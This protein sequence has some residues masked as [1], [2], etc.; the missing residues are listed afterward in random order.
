M[1][2]LRSLLNKMNNELFSML[3][4]AITTETL[5]TIEV[6][7]NTKKGIIGKI[8]TK[9]KGVE[10]GA[11]AD[12]LNRIVSLYPNATSRE[13]F[14]ELVHFLHWDLQDASGI[15]KPKSQTMTLVQQAWEEG[16][17]V[18]L[19]MEHSVRAL[20]DIEYPNAKKPPICQKLLKNLGEYYKSGG[21][22]ELAV[23]RFRDLAMAMERFQQAEQATKQEQKNIKMTQ[24]ISDIK[25]I[26]TSKAVIYDVGYHFLFD[27]MVALTS[28]SLSMQQ[29]IELIMTNRPES[30][31]EILNPSSYI[32]RLVTTR[33]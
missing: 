26:A 29:A 19:E 21:E 16:I 5:P 6:L 30:L 9:A 13:V 10:M 33:N 18:F 25:T 15:K 14:H 11:K 7:G 23:K 3:G 27:V 12:R 31:E 2:E 28:R 1:D 8:I 4:M 20:V 24:M 32:A 22:F 17:A